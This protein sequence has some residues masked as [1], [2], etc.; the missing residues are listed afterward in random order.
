MH[1]LAFAEQREKQ[2]KKS[3][4]ETVQAA[5][6]I[7]DQLGAKFT[8]LVVGSDVEGAASELGK[9]GAERVLVVDVPQLARHSVPSAGVGI[10]RPNGKGRPVCPSHSAHC[11]ARRA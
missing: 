11:R 6:G 10:H 5:R 1:I 2:L 7:A 8:A 4:F 9:Y 3:S